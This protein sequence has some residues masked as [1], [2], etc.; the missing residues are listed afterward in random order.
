MDYPRLVYKGPATHKLVE[1]DD[2]HEAALAEG[3]KATAS[4]PV[5]AASEVAVPAAKAA[6]VEPQP[7]PKA[8][9]K[10]TSKKRR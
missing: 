10:S 2:E 1:N 6:A 3:W 9:A 4:E 7:D 8:E 5:G